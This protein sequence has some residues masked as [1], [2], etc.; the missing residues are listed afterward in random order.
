MR[1]RRP[2][3]GGT[4]CGCASS[5]RSTPRPKISFLLTNGYRT[6]VC[7][8]LT[9]TS[10]GS[11]ADASVMRFSDTTNLLVAC[12]GSL[13]RAIGAGGVWQRRGSCKGTRARRAAALQHAW[14]H[15]LHQLRNLSAPKGD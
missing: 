10:P 8:G 11:A 15:N 12:E 9:E 1:L 4:I 6:C 14:Q 13:L 3:L 7:A 2:G 5:V